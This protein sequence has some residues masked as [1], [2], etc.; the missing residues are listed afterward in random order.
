MYCI[1]VIYKFVSLAW[2][3]RTRFRLQLTLNFTVI[4]GAKKGERGVKTGAGYFLNRVQ[5]GLEPE[6]DIFPK[7]AAKVQQFFG[8]C[9]F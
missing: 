6:Q 3:R 4:L 2:S 9:K 8:I 1:Y 5:T 7:S